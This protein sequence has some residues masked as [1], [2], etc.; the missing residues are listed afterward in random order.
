MF[1]FHSVTAPQMLRIA[2]WGYRTK[3]WAQSGTFS[4]GPAIHLSEL[5]QTA[6]ENVGV[7]GKN[8]TTELFMFVVRVTDFLK[9]KAA[10]PTENTAVGRL[11]WRFRQ[12]VNKKQAQLLPEFLIEYERVEK[13]D[14]LV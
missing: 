7:T 5:P 12:I 10:G 13:T 11:K 1:L 3:S 14:L 8:R 9:H 2:E 6:D 4:R